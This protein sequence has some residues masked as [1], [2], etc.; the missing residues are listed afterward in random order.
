[1]APRPEVWHQP[2]AVTILDLGLAEIG[3]MRHTRGV[4]KPHGQV[5]SPGYRRAGRNRGMVH[6]T[7]RHQVD[8]YSSKY[9]CSISVEF[10]ENSLIEY[11]ASIRVFVKT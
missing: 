2:A 9:I 7:A 4:P 10:S 3:V 1:M 11:P 5:S 8:N 6:P